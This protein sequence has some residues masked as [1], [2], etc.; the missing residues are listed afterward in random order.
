M[1][2]DLDCP[3][4]HDDLDQVDPRRAHEP[5]GAPQPREP[6]RVEPPAG[7]RGGI[8]EVAWARL[9]QSARL[10][11][12]GDPAAIPGDDQVEL[13]GRGA[14]AAAQ[15]PVAAG[16]E[17]S[18]GEALA[19]EAELVRSEA[20]PGQGQAG[21]E[22][23]Q[24]S[25]QEPESSAPAVT[26]AL[27]SASSPFFFSPGSTSPWTAERAKRN[28]TLSSTCSVITSPWACTTVP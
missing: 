11:L 9:A 22:A 4:G 10:H 16:P 15:D 18:G 14:D 7:A 8:E 2:Q 21:R 5:R 17:M 6:P 12:D 25:G 3:A 28:R 13:A 23:R 27:A 26:T 1:V 19:G 20:Q 24:Q